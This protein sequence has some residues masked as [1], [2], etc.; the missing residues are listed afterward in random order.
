MGEHK[1]PG[2]VS[3]QGPSLLAYGLFVLILNCASFSANTVFAKA[4][5]FRHARSWSRSLLIAFFSR[6]TCEKGLH[7]VY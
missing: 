7:V 1:K 4:N 3:P 2:L 5:A 6:T